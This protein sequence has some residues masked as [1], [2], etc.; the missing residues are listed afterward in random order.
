MHP[1]KISKSKIE[2]GECHYYTVDVAL[3]KV[4]I[5]VAQT[6]Q[7]FRHLNDSSGQLDL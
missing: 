5:D 2:T 1:E 3:C 4:E 7:N 6:W